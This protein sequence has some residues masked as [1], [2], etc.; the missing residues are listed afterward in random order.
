[1]KR[2][3]TLLLTIV[4][5]GTTFAGCYSENMITKESDP[6]ETATNSNSEYDTGT[7]NIQHLSTVP[8]GFVG[9]YTA[10]DFDYLR[11]S[12]TGQYILMNDIDMTSIDTWEGINF[13]GT[14]DGNNYEIK[15]YH[16][17]NGF[18]DCL[19]NATV[20]NI[21][22]T[23]D[24]KNVTYRRKDGTWTQGI[25]VLANTIATSNS[26]DS[27]AS[28]T[29]CKIKGNIFIQKAI[30]DGFGTIAGKILPGSPSSTVVISNVVNEAEIIAKENNFSVI[31]GIIGEVIQ[32]N[33]SDDCVTALELYNAVN[34]GNITVE[35][36]VCTVGGI[37]GYGAGSVFY[38]DNYG[39]I[40]I[41]CDKAKDNENQTDDGKY[42]RDHSVCGGIIGKNGD[43][44]YWLGEIKYGYGEI[45]TIYSC[46]NYGS[47]TSDNCEF[48]GG[49]IGYTAVSY[50][51]SD[52]GNFSNINAVNSGGIQGGGYHISPLS[53]CINTGEIYGS[54]MSGAIIGDFFSNAPE[55]QNCYYLN[56]GVNSVGVKAV[57]PNVYM[58]EKNQLND[59]SKVN[60]G[61]LW[62]INNECP[63]L[64][65]TLENKNL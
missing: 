45:G 58:I 31:G 41:K 23:A 65:S 62:T 49:I 18:F 7:T 20:S 16:F 2:I 29:N 30:N 15:N 53:N 14:F 10:D 27:N 51:L 34:R 54:K 12:S 33:G 28:I 44:K 5:I 24:M 57:F 4:I 22:I 26:N 42:E 48:A 40:N 60:L 59:E 56:N 50:N 32:Q 47:I 39:N 25:G 6:N 36:Q 52:C 17:D 64:Y 43:C 46:S 38:C 37:I 9:I 11:N 1:M 3:F 21:N 55:P 13:S 63:K 35:N 61:S 8:D 19:T